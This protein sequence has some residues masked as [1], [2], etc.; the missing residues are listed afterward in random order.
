MIHEFSN[1]NLVGEK[2]VGV[3]ISEKIASER[4]VIRIKNVPHVQIF[5][6]QRVD[7]LAYFK[8][9]RKNPAT[10]E[11]LIG[12][13][14]FPRKQDHEQ[15]G[16]VIQLMGANQLRVKCEDGETRGCRIPGKLKKK[17]W[18][19]DG[20]LVIVKVWDFQPIKG[21]VVWRYLPPQ[22][23]YLRRKGLLTKLE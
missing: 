13:I 21:D 20:D 19:R 11:E 4:N 23:N 9:K 12:R 16:F 10:E 3:A 15:L 17:V 18:I 6:I 22:T 14:R 8:K 2:S 5:T 1:I 7:N